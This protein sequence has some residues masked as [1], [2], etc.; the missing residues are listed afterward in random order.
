MAKNFWTVKG[1]AEGIRGSVMILRCAPQRGW[2]GGRDHLIDDSAAQALAGSHYRS[3]LAAVRAGHA[4]RD[5]SAAV[6]ILV[7]TNRGPFTIDT[8]ADFGIPGRNVPAVS[9]PW[10]GGAP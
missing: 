3:L 9:R 8:S 2:T 5:T 10:G 1:A 4:A 6:T 7:A